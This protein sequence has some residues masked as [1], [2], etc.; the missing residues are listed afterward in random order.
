MDEEIRIG[1]FICHCGV[2]IASV[3]DVEAV[4]EYSMTLENVVISDTNLFSCSSLGQNAIID[5][6]KNENLNRVVVAAC[7]PKMHEN[8]FRKAIGEGG[9]NPHL[10]EMVNIR[11]QSAWVHPF[12]PIG[13]TEKA[14]TLIRMGVAKARL[15]EPIEIIKSKVTEKVLVIGGGV[16]GL[17]SSLDAADR[18]LTVT[19]VERSPTLGGNAA[20]IGDLVHSNKKGSEITSELIERVRNNENITIFTNS[21]VDEVKGSYGEYKVAI[22]QEPRYV[23]D[24]CT[25]PEKG[26]EV[27]PEET[28]NEYEFNLT[29]RKAMFKP[30]DNAYPNTYTID[31]N[32]CTKCNKCVETCEP[33]SIDLNME[34]ET[35]TDI[36][37]TIITAIGYD[38]Y[39]PAIGEFGYRENPQV[40]T[41][42]QL[43]RM[44]DQ[45][46]SITERFNLSKEPENIV[47]ISCV[48]SM[49]DPAIEGSN[50]YCSRMCCSASF[51]NMIRLKDQYPESNIFFLYRDIRTYARREERLYEQ[52]SDKQV[53]FIR[54]E[55]EN[56]PVVNVNGGLNVE[57]YDKL[58]R[59]QLM[60]PSDLIVLAQG[61]VPSKGYQSTSE[62]LKLPCTTEGW[63]SEAHAKLRPVEIPAPGIYIAGSAQGPKDI[64]ES[65]ISASA[66]ASKAIIP[67]IQGE[68]EL[69]PLTSFVNEDTCGACGI[70]ISTCPYDAVSKIELEDGRHVA[71]VDGKL[72]AGC[73]QCAGGCPSGAMQQKSFKDNQMYSMINEVV[74]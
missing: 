7:S 38:P 20:R 15:L 54:Y 22:T 11:E 43:E 40:I 9:L 57:V 55:L 70:C 1:V 34:P 18:G 47:F 66:A 2:N 65:V 74:Q 6:I 56:A 27:C 73:G 23:L 63:I 21:T 10:L 39:E 68:V 33:G 52:A 3:I 67:V 71:H 14:K 28:L 42:L 12:D 25:N 36:F 59:E 50:T 72:C 44:L 48:G 29:T 4:M 60:I 13:A 16:A 46:I 51:K 41:L 64:I 26:E 58:V 62:I 61:M 35:V 24:S 53:L 30:F 19:L 5:A 69:E 32:I 49:Q 37:G 31:M 8:T 17:R 45:N